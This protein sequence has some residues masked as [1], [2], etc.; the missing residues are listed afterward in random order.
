MLFFC[1]YCAIIYCMND[2]K[3]DT[4]LHTHSI[5]SGHGSTDT[6]EAMA[7][8][9]AARGLRLL[10]VSE[11]GPATPASCKES[12][13]M[14]LRYA[15]RRRSGIDMLYGAEL[16]I[17][18]MDGSIDLPDKICESLDYCIISLHPPVIR[19]DAGEDYTD[20]YI[21]A[22]KH[23]HVLFIGHADDGRYPV[24]Y[25]RLLR[26]S[27]ELH[28]Y[29]EINNASLCPDAYRV[30]GRMNSMRMLEICKSIRL[31]VLLSSDSHG[32]THIGDMSCI[33]PLLKECSFP[34]ALI[35]NSSLGSA[36]GH[37]SCP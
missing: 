25:E 12:Y 3:I 1:E 11:H 23:P 29:P 33:M 36:D 5:A 6:I 24:D 8:T 17:C 22:M 14:G 35:L 15:S 30:N 10:G 27:K 7:E 18:G 4:D 34:E 21:N 16:N 20:A 31:P 9:A 26:A 13:F 32:K 28:I 37:L 2:Y 19:P